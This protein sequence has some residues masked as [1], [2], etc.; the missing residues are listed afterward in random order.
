VVR[1]RIRN[2]IVDD[3]AYRWTVSQVDPGHVK[4]K[5]WRDGVLEVLATFDDPWLNYGPIIT[6]PAGRAAEVFDLSPITPD[7]VAKIV[8]KALD[9]GWQPHH[10]ATMRLRLTRDRE[11]VEAPLE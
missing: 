8:R 1:A 2:I 5:V 10:R 4:V 9:A 11:R 3:I 7:L 6:A